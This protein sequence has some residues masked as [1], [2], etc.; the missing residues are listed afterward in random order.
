MLNP[1]DRR[2]LAC[3]GLM[4]LVYGLAVAP[5][6]HAVVEHG[7]GGHHHL[8]HVHGRPHS[9][10]ARG[11]HAGASA[12]A[13]RHEGTARAQAH[14][15]EDVA[16]AHRGEDTAREHAHRHEGSAREHAHRHE[17]GS[18]GAQMHRGE[19]AAHAHGHQHTAATTA[20]SD[21]TPRADHNAPVEPDSQQ[22]GHEHLTGSVEHLQAVALAWAVL[23][24]PRVREVWWLEEARPGP[25]R[26]LGAT[27]RP[28][29][30][31]QG[32]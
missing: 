1:H 13:Y 14:R 29:A 25:S 3:L 2:D 22:D 4:V 9:H 28:T 23:K 7:G 26:V 20:H 30:M 32:P 27:V 19:D 31:P 24:L 21:S 12:H 16:R 10:G 8:A 11:E 6:L 18:A 5:V 15:G 17:E